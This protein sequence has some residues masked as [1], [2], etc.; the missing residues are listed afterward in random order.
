MQTLVAA[1]AFTLLSAEP[2]YG[3]QPMKQ[4]P[5]KMQQGAK[6]KPAKPKAGMKMKEEAAVLMESDLK[7]GDPPPGLP[8]GSQLAVLSGDPMKQ[9]PFIV[10]LKMPEGYKIPAHWHSNA[11]R[12]TILSGTLSMRMGEGADAPLKDLETH[13]FYSSKARER[14]SVEAKTEVIVQI[15]GTGPFDIHYVNPSDDPRKQASR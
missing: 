2:P 12:L 13:A 8:K 15:E 6:E 3:E 14:H 4:Q 5:S 11:E 7:W 1:L 10:R 9:G